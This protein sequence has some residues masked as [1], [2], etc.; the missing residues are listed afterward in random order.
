MT[1]MSENILKMSSNKY[2]QLCLNYCIMQIEFV[3]LLCITFVLS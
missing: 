1:E 3:L 2:V